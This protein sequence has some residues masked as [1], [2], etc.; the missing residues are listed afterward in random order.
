MIKVLVAGAN[1]FLGREVALKCIGMGWVTDA[2]VHSSKNML[3]DGIS[4]VKDCLDELE[5]HYDYIFNAAAFIPYGA[6][7]KPDPRF[8]ESNLELPILLYKKYPGSKMIFASTVAVYGK[9][10]GKLKED[11]AVMSPT[12]YGQSKLAGEMVTNLFADFSIIRFSSIFGK[13]ML[14]T[15]FLPAICMQA[16]QKQQIMISGDGSRRQDYIHL[17][18]A[19]EYMI[20]G[21]LHGKNKVYLGV[22]GISFSN[23]EIA[24]MVSKLAGDSSVI[25]YGVD[26]S[27]SF[28]YDNS[29]SRRDLK[30]QP[31]VSMAKGIEELLKNV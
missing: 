12:L 13:K 9:N 10:Q 28:E 15:T 7:N 4:K 18:D 19:S 14:Q 30:F 6:Y 11:S 31:L 25:Y 17:S 8:L 16:K 20:K 2:L 5:D 22:N 23:K 26:D 24:L 3:P 21:A 27:P 1:G 29:I